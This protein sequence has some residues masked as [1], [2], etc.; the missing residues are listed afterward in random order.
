[1][2]ERQRLPDD[3]A[4]CFQVEPTK[5]GAE[6]LLSARRADPILAIETEHQPGCPKW[7]HPPGDAGQFGAAEAYQGMDVV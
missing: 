6:I 1:M 4:K 5:A 7:R 2:K 3:E